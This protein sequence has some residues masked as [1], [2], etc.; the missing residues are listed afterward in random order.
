MGLAH[1]IRAQ[2]A[3]RQMHITVGE[4]SFLRLQGWLVILVYLF[5]PNANHTAGTG[6]SSQYGQLG[7]ASRSF[8]SLGARARSPKV[9]QFF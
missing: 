2:R 9:G 6:P 1:L 7:L 4:V 3:K 5:R 8:V